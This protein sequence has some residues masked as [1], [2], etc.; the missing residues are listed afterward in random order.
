MAQMPHLNYEKKLWQKGYLVIGV[1]EVG[2]GALAGP[3][4]AAACL[5]SKGR[6]FIK[7]SS[8]QKIKIA[9]SKKLTPKQRIVAYQWIKKNCLACSLSKIGVDAINKTGIAKASVS[10]MRQAIKQL[11]I[12]V[13]KKLNNNKLFVLSDYF[14]IP[15]LKNI[16]INHQKPI[17]HGDEI[18]FS[19]ASASIIAKVE[20]DRLMVKL[21]K[22][23]PFYRWE[24]NKGYGTLKHRGVIKKHGVTKHHR[25]LFVRNIL[26]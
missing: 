10:A 17:V 23:Y 5:F 4:M 6:N 16:G 3:V 20:R 25:S 21:A 7:E 12:K 9:D 8:S 13:A 15:H 14:Y 22:Q 1:D 26:E 11:R 18:S 24:K 19:I 2:R